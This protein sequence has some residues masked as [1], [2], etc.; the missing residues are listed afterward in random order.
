MGLG[1]FIVFCVLVVLLVWGGTSLV[2]YFGGAN[3]ATAIANKLII[4]I[5]IL[6]ILVK[7][8]QAVGLTDYK[9]PHF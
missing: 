1:E 7:F 4:G 3:A 5:G 6:L 9:I 8:I 2:S